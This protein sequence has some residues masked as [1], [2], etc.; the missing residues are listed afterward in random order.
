MDAIG[1]VKRKNIPFYCEKDE[2]IKFVDR[3]TDYKY[4]KYV[5]FEL[6]ASKSG[7][8]EY[9]LQVVNG[10]III[11]ATSGNAGGMAL[12]AYLKKYCK[13]Q[14]GILCS[15]GSVPECP[16]ET[17]EIISDQSV[18]HYRYAF[19]YCTYGYS[20]AFN[21]W[22]DWERITDYLILAGYN[23]VL[24]PI[25]NEC[26]W[27]ELLQKFNYTREE[28]KKYISAPNYLPWQ[29]MMN[30]SAF[31]SEYPDYWFSEQQEISRKFNKKLKDFGMGALMPGYCG[32]VPDD[33]TDKYPNAKILPQ[34]LWC[35][36][37]A[38][39]AILLP[40][41]ELF[42][43]I[44]REYYKLQK[45]LLGS[46][47]HHYY[48]TDPFHEGGN[49]GDVD[50][51]GYATS[52][53][54]EMR[55]GDKDAVWALQGWQKNPDRQILSA[56]NK[57]DVLIMNL[58]A[59]E[60]PDGGDDFLGYPHV[61]CLVNNFGG[62][63]ALRG[64]AKKTYYTAHAMANDNNS[65]CVGIGII[66]EGVECD[67]ILYDINL[68]VAMHKQLRDIREYL[69]EYIGARYGVQSEEL[70]DAFEILFDKV[71]TVDT[72]YYAHESGLIAKPT[73][74]ANRVCYWAA[75][76]LLEDVSP[77][78]TVSEILL[79]YYDKCCSRQGYI[80]DL[81]AVARQLLGNYSWHHIYPLNQAFKDGD[82]KAFNEHKNALLK[83]FPLQER[84][85]DCDENLNLQK[86]LDR[87]LKRGK[88]END[89]R[90]LM[91]VVKLLITLWGG[92]KS[93]TLHDY[94]PREFGDMVRFYYRPRWEKYLEVLT[95][96]LEN[97]KDFVDYDRFSVDEEFINEYRLY[98]TAVSKDLKSAVQDT[99]R[100]IKG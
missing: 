93:T 78:I 58:H 88:T 95:D 74:D 70:I 29:W 90:W 92:R 6:V 14:F 59:D 89:K 67:E 44:S 32:A 73:L 39:P 86:F 50:L 82:K 34:G 97:G 60:N 36:V 49:K 9:S 13:F 68:E 28:A 26:V 25:G 15:S 61:Y 51:K 10:K 27:L 5:D 94:S 53:L 8:D 42:S 1:N 40:E 76:S 18:F 100:E 37:F 55:Y 22:N 19:N 35:G 4:G 2:F 81:V 11:K 71:Y 46:E 33:F 64:S 62:E 79:K 52:V 54:S 91:R 17:N 80:A 23:L 41:N 87:A 77:L 48:S 31:N 20:Y 96:C 69:G 75:P 16:P 30:L 83:L 56:L 24:N 66:P 65:A 72:Y 38:R 43:Q 21:D 3:V 63:H 85:I 57:E 12:N 47:D 45:D 7:F 98:S 99:I 84:V